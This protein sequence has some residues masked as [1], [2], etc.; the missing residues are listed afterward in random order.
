MSA[1]AAYVEL[2]EQLGELVRSLPAHQLA[3]PVPACP[4]WTVHDV[5]AHLAGV[6]TDNVTGAV[7]TDS[8]A[9]AL[10]TWTAGH[11]RSRADVATTVVLREWERF[12]SQLEVL[13]NKDAMELPAALLD[14]ATHDD[15]IREAVDRPRGLHT[16]THLAMHRGLMRRWMGAIERAGLDPIL[17][18]L[19]TGDPYDGEVD[20]DVVIR[21]SPHW[22]YRSAMGRQSRASVRSKF[23]SGSN[24]DA[25]IDLLYVFDPG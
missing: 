13:L 17:V 7:P 15:D 22:L 14:L 8:S 1:G 9:D 25:Y 4:D 19:P 21:S 3:T 10:D 12:S 18:M 24:L 5:V 11:V 23:V 6:A 20:A 2:R 16:D